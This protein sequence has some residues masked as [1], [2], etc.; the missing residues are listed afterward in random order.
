MNITTIVYY[1]GDSPVSKTGNFGKQWTSD[2]KIST[3]T[4]IIAAN[5]TGPNDNSTLKAQIII[6]GKVVKESPASS[7]KTLQ[8]NLSLY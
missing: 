2:A 1:D 8:A 5:G 7:G 4:P 6:D 3:K